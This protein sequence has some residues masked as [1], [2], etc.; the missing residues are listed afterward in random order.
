MYYLHT[1]IFTENL[2]Q[3]EKFWS[4]LGL[5]VARRMEQPTM[6]A[7]FMAA[8]NDMESARSERFTPTVA[9]VQRKNATG[10]A[11]VSHACYRVEDV[12]ATCQMLLDRGMT[13]KMPPR[14]GFR[15]MVRDPDGAIIEFHQIGERKTPAEPWIS[16]ADGA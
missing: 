7:A 9:L 5:D 3:S 1:T 14:D 8:P 6:T 11:G 16:M 2:E 15:A 4:T 12:Y 10:G 13:L